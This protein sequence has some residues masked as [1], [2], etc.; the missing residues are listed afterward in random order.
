MEN[1]VLRGN[2]PAASSLWAILGLPQFSAG[3]FP[4]KSDPRRAKVR[5]WVQHS[6]EWEATSS[7]SRVHGLH[8]DQEL[9]CAR[10]LLRK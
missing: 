2:K 1:G 5:G 7:G 8:F 6:G 4:D 10:R 3:Q 9:C